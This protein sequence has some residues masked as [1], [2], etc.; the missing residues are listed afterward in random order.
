M[1]DTVAETSTHLCHDLPCPRCGHGGHHF[2]PCDHC[3]CETTAS[4]TDPTTD[5]TG[6]AARN[7][8]SSA[9]V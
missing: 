2:L 4:T 9:S 6:S 8:Q 1:W 5:S 7:R 3:A